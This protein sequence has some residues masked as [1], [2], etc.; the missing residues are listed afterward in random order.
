MGC[1]GRL[2]ATSEPMLGPLE[3]VPQSLLW[4]VSNKVDRSHRLDTSHGKLCDT[5]LSLS[6][7][8]GFPVPIGTAEPDLR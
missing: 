3:R 7:V 8:V 5:G 4:V 2:S 1:S 6:T